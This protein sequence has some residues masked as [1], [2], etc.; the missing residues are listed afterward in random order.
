MPIAQFFKQFIQNHREG[1]KQALP[2][3]VVLLLTLLLSRKVI[4]FGPLAYGDIP[5]FD[6]NSSKINFLYTWDAQQMGTNVRQGFNTIR[7]AFLYMAAWNNPVYYFLKFVLPVLLI[8]VTYFFVL[9]KLGI[10]NSFCLV[11]CAVLPLLTPIVF[12]DYLTGQ[13]FW[14][15]LTVPW[16][17]YFAIKIFYC[18]DFAISNSVW[19]AVLLFLSLGMLP[20]IIVPL[21]AVLGIFIALSFLFDLV[22]V[23]ARTLSNYAVAGMVILG[24]FGV[25]SSPYLLAASSGQAAYTPVTLLSDYYHNY[26]FT[27]FLNTF[28]LAGNNG[29]GQS[30]LGYNLPSLSNALGYVFLLVIV[31]GILLLNRVRLQRKY[32]VDAVAGL[33]V[34]LL[35]IAG[36][37]HLMSVNTAFG[38]KVFESQWIVSTIRNPSKIYV[39][40]LPICMLAFAFSLERILHITQGKARY[41]VGGLVVMALMGYGWPALRGDLGLLAR[42]EGGLQSYR[43]DSRVAA[44]NEELRNNAEQRSLLLPSDHKDELNYQ[45]ITPG[46]NV[47]QLQGGLPG[48]GVVVNEMKAALNSRSQYFFNYLDST[49]IQNVFAKTD[50]ESYKAATF[51]LFSVKLTPEEANQF[52]DSRLHKTSA[53]DGYVRY[54]NNMAN[55]L[56]YSPQNIIAIQGS[57][58]IEP[59]AAFLAQNTAVIDS[60]GRPHLTE[61]YKAEKTL[62]AGAAVTKGKAQLHDASLLLLDISSERQG[63]RKYVVID[64]LDPLTKQVQSTARQ[65]V[66][67][68]AQVVAIGDQKYTFGSAKKRL[69]I[70][71]GSYKVRTFAL[72]RV[73]LGNSDPSFEGKSLVS[74]GSKGKPG[75]ANMYSRIVDDST[76]RKHALMIGTANH[77][78]FTEK[79]LPVEDRAGYL[80]GFDYKNT[81]GLPPRYM[82]TDNDTN[83]M[84]G[85]GR[86]AEGNGW[87]TQETFFDYSDEGLPSDHKA[88]LYLYTDAQK[89]QP[90]ENLFDNVR[91]WKLVERASFQVALDSYP[92]DYDLTNYQMDNQLPDTKNMI[93]NGS[94]EDDDLWGKVGD[95]S[96][97][98]EGNPKLSAKQS[99]DAAK[100]AVS[101]EL[102][103]SNHVAYMSQKV[104]A[105]QPNNIY[106]VSFYYKHVTGRPAAF[107]MW[108]DGAN[109]SA[110][111]QDLKGGH[112]WTY[113]ETYFVPDPKTTNLTLY[114]YSRSAGEKTVNLF[115]DVKVEK[116]SLVSTYLTQTEAPSK[117]PANLVKNFRK[118]SPVRMEAT[119]RPGDGMVV[120]NESY[121]KG[122]R[123]TVSD[124]EGRHRYTLSAKDHIMVNGFANGWWIDSA[125]LPA[126][127]RKHDYR[128]TLTY[129]PQQKFQKYLV[130]S[131]TG[132]AT[133]MGYIAWD[134]WRRKR[135]LTG[136]VA[137]RYRLFS[138]KR[139]S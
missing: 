8:P 53:G 130:I 111:S 81:K 32:V 31:G 121:Q 129:A 1:I 117:R 36:F 87:Q 78:G 76:D 2:F 106:K 102:A 67:N 25:L 29:N 12:G 126:E 103:S 47:L 80:L 21:F 75:K 85:N 115:D 132:L 40:L 68:D 51:G 100:G 114:L 37:M 128:L 30:T 59:K 89:R 131:L 54:T 90:S 110:P 122:W 123:A 98:A 71:S 118:V 109:I 10:K 113:F 5:L 133:C 79:I 15:Y 49:G 73:N 52:I 116:T 22:S 91:L 42:R 104:S 39:I 57:K 112:D 88:S 84:F 61:I 92:A 74:D 82:L 138:G 77:S 99:Y 3:C 64:V 50:K 14:I 18:K 108:Q 35:L 139:R 34:V 65:A 101:L 58:D 60:P 93:R 124:A 137:A 94:F 41:I 136:E 119:L 96:A 20:P 33:V 62:P 107:A 127:L 63:S 19:L 48:T 46:L 95:A 11:L 45:N 6:V 120:F 56:L 69:T 26:L 13:T 134:S 66:D 44:I 83:G 28:R 125:S 55:N 70:T 86:L 17:F 38:V 105:Y 23:N 7:D 27:D 43:A 16:V 24:V 9:R 135:A 72:D 97:N 4:G